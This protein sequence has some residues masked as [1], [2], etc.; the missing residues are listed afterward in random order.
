[1]AFIIPT[2]IKECG[3]C[4]RMRV[5]EGFMVCCRT[6]AV[7]DNSV[8]LTLCDKVSEKDCEFESA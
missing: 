7:T 2:I 3:M 1:M 4:T 6:M 8:V 5:I